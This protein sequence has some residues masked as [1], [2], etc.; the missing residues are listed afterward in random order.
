MWER[1]KNRLRIGGE[2][3]TE[4]GLM[5]YAISENGGKKRCRRTK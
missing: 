2:P 4:D 1:I 3:I 5:N